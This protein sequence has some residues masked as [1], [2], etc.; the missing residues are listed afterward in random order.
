M[1]QMISVS[2]EQ[3][4]TFR[5]QSVGGIPRRKYYTPDGKEVY[6]IVAERQYYDPKTKTNG[7]RDANLDKGWLLEPPKELKIHCPNCDKWH[8]TKSEVV[9]CGQE[10]RVMMAKHTRWA[11]KQLQQPES[12]PEVEEL[13][14][15]LAEV[16]ALLRQMI[17]GKSGPLFQRDANELAQDTGEVGTDEEGV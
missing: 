1:T 14:N 11:K 7:I 16:K 5:A 6:G 8:D 13:K 3:A 2:P 10:R 12:S 4:S 9:K 15:E 17:G